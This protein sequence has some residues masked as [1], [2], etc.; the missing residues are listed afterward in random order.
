MTLRDQ[1]ALDIRQLGIN[2]NHWYVVAQSREVT[3]KPLGIT[4]WNQAIVLYRDSQGNVCALEDRCLHRQVKLSHGVV[5]SDAVKG[6]RLECAYHGWCFGGAGQCVAVPYLAADQKL[7]QQRIRSFPACEQNGFIWI[8]PAF[9]AAETPKV[10]S[11][12]PQPLVSDWALPIA[13]P[14][15]IISTTSPPFLS[16]SA[17]LT[18]PI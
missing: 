12:S 6:D 15:G 16:S 17:A 13:M 3:T 7:P 5:I 18:I 11:E 10:A 2:P 8:F 4:L 1:T 9:P 14:E